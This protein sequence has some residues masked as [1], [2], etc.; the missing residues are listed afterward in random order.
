[1]QLVNE[2]MKLRQMTKDVKSF[3]AA[4]SAK[5]V[6]LEERFKQSIREIENQK[7]KFMLQIEKVKRLTPYRKHSFDLILKSIFLQ[8]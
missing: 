1:M 4:N 5:Q 3:D 7:R 8:F 2:N 6:P